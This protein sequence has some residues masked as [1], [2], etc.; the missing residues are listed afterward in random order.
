M[1][2]LPIQNHLDQKYIDALLN[3]SE[4]LIREIYKR[5]GDKIKTMVLQQ[6]GNESDTADIIQEA[7]LSIFNRAK[8]GGFILTCPFEG[9]FHLVCKRKWIKELKKRNKFKVT[10]SNIETFNINDNSDELAKECILHEERKAFIVQMIKKLEI[11]CKQLL[12]DLNDKPMEE[13][14]AILNITY[15]YARKKK[16][17]CKSDL[18][19][20]IHNSPEYNSLKE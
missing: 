17:E 2:S 20:L 18:I 4:G 15:N 10:I 3:N 6:G 9:F 13:V 7:L 14:A 12:L 8:S 5:F 1:N 19:N 11:K 16:S